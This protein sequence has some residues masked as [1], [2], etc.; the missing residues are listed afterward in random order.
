MKIKIK[1]ISSEYIC[2]EWTHWEGMS[3]VWGKVFA[4]WVYRHQFIATTWEAL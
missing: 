4:K 2:T 1:I 3:L